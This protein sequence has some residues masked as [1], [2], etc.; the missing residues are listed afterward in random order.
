MKDKVD[1]I[2]ALGILGEKFRLISRNRNYAITPNG[3]IIYRFSR[4]YPDNTWWVA[5]YPEKMLD[6]DY[7]ILFLNTYGIVVV[8]S[9][10]IYQYGKDNHVRLLKGGRQSFRIRVENGHPVIY[11]KVTDPTLDLFTYFYPVN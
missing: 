8:P 6:Y 9:K 7:I 3:K 11:N 5:E 1:I 10:V 2:T 4:K